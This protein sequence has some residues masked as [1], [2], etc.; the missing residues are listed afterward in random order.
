MLSRIT[1]IGL[2]RPLY[3]YRPTIINRFPT[4][5]IKR[6]N[7]SKA[8]YNHQYHQSTGTNGESGANGTGENKKK[9]TG[10]KALVKEYGW[11]AL[12]VYL[13]LSCIDYP[14]CFMAVHSVGEDKIHEYQ[15]KVKKFI[16]MEV[17]PRPIPKQQT[18]EEQEEDG[19]DVSDEEE[20]LWSRIWNSTLFTEAILAYGIHKSLIFIRLPITAAITPSIVSKLRKMG[21]NI[22][23]T[24]FSSLAQ[25][26][27]YKTNLKIVDSKNA[28]AN[29]KEFG[30]PVTKRQKWWS[31][32]F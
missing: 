19:N 13:G 11:S 25:Q 26:A 10:I 14:L 27:K 21:F 29:N 23:S 4:Q 12:A 28:V 5:G 17:K 16:G 30:T 20:S 1:N 2:R 8:N 15:D 31:W 18:G 6:F 7:T 24:K 9:S 32:F 22:G 3:H